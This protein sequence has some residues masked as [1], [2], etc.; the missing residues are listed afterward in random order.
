MNVKHFGALLLALGL[1]AVGGCFLLPRAT[2]PEPAGPVIGD[3]SVRVVRD[4]AAYPDV[5]VFLDDTV[6]VVLDGHVAQ[7]LEAKY[8]SVPRAYCATGARAADGRLHVTSIQQAAD[9][10]VPSCPT[11]APVVLVRPSCDLGAADMF[12]A[13]VLRR[14][15]FV[16]V[17]CGARRLLVL[18]DP[19]SSE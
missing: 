6:A 12:D 9:A 17:Q 15:P 14:R 1:L 7:E 13:L 2:A 4:S 3:S 5:E 18:K 16:A 19:S 8:S 11:G 10:S